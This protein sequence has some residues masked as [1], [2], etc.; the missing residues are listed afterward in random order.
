MTYDARCS[1]FGHASLVPRLPTWC[2]DAVLLDATRPSRRSSVHGRDRRSARSASRAA[3]RARCCGPVRPLVRASSSQR[4][5]RTR[6]GSESRAVRLGRRRAMRCVVDRTA[7]WLHGVDAPAAERDPRDADRR[8]LQPR[9]QPA[10][11]C[12]RGQ[13][14]PRP[15]AWRHRSS[16]VTVWRVTTRLR[17]GVRPGRL[18]WRLRC[19]RGD[20]RV[21]SARAS[22][23]DAADGDEVDR[24]K[25]LPRSSAC[26]AGVRDPGD[27]GADRGPESALAVLTGTRRTSRLATAPIRVPDDD[28]TALPAST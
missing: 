28:G 2:R 11:A 17:D 1:R 18:L 15:A 23:T 22:T 7:A 20:R 26:C 25:G 21:P 4:R 27:G 9:R 16:S 3:A 5:C 13:R 24:F 14:D 12:R 8:P 6:F 10:S 19:A